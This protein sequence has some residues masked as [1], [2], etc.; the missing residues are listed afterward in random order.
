[1]KINR[2]IALAAIALLVV[3]AMG[4]IT[5][6]GLALGFK[7]HHPQIVAT[8]AP[9]PGI[10]GGQVGDQGS[11]IKDT[12][13]ITDTD[14][15][16]E[17]VGEQGGIITD[18]NNITDTNHEQVGDQGET[19]TDT[20]KIT[21]TDHVDEQ[22]GDQG[23]A[24]TNHG[25]EQ[26]SDRGETITDTQDITDTNNVNEQVGDQGSTDTNNGNEQVGDQ[27]GSGTSATGSDNETN[28]STLQ[29]QAKITVEQAQQAALAAHPGGTILR[30]DLDD[31]NGKLV[32]SV[33]FTDGTEVKLD[34]TTGAVLP[35]ENGEH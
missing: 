21:D 9:N 2:F 28:Q 15:V 34:A 32:Y 30:T 23:S 8:Q 3:G 20:N 5:V 17:Q 33:E 13:N 26:V 11:A 12:N 7:S 31:E 16:E 6:R 35:G 1:M 10:A 24:D 22:V 29:S 27:N 25:D 19:I 4:F 18:T 14:K